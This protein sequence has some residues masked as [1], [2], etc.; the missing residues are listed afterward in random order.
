MLTDH[1]SVSQNMKVLHD[2][3]LVLANCNHSF[4][5]DGMLFKHITKDTKE[6]KILKLDCLHFDR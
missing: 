2:L 1:L 5:S 4:P 6:D 3:E